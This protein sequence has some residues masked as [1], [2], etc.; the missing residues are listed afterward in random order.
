MT[1]TPT[2][3]P[4]PGPAPDATVRRATVPD[5]TS[6][7]RYAGARVPGWLGDGRR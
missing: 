4:V 1:A 6:L 7:D 2:T 5:G 3:A